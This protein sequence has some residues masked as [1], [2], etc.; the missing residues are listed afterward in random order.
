MELK[1]NRK[2]RSYYY[3]EPSDALPVSSISN[4]SACITK[5]KGYFTGINVKI[6][7]NQHI[8][9]IYKNGCF[10]ISS[11]TKSAPMTLWKHKKYARMTQAMYDKKIE[12]RDK[13]SNQASLYLNNDVEIVSDA[14]LSGKNIPSTKA[15][16]QLDETEEKPVVKNIVE[17]PFPLEESLMLFCEEAFFLHYTL[18]CLD[19]FDGDGNT[20][21][22]E[23][24]FVKF[25]SINWKFI[26]NFV[27][28]QYLRSKNWIVKS[29]LKFGGDFCELF[30]NFCSFFLS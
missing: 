7:E 25:T 4:E 8:N 11:I 17:D 21:S 2:K 22:S 5:Y 9:S 10:G 24:L 26:R 13:F 28:Y 23:Q 6:V 16:D 30:N 15:A 19:I 1:L 18:K 20:L 27:A 12:W 3:R 14:E 29:G